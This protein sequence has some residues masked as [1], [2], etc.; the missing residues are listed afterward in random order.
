MSGKSRL[1]FFEQRVSDAGQDITLRAL[2][3]VV[4]EMSAAKGFSRH[5]GSDY[6]EH[7]ID[8]AQDLWNF[9]IKDENI[10]SAAL[11][12]DV[13]EDVTGV[14]HKMLVHE[15]NTDIA[16]IVLGVT[17]KPDVDYKEG[18]NI[19]VLYLNLI[20]EDSRQCLIK[21]SDRKHNF[22]TLRDATPEKKLRQA[23]ETEKYFF[24]F[25]K[26][27]R[28]KYPRYSA[29][30]NSAKTIILPHLLEIGDHYEEVE[31]LKTIIE[32]QNEIIKKYDDFRASF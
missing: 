24:P 15:F 28:R 23:K 4:K 22:S 2:D 21:T 14:T 8:V 7:C 12:H 25:F 1:A 31:A 18:N 3:F 19:E 9:G 20:L 10:I 26:E 17:K 16:D 11:L 6:Y 27:A 32:E 5:D 30:F 13:I 29:Y